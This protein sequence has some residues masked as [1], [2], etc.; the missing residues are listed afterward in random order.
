M[1]FKKLITEPTM[2]VTGIIPFQSS[3]HKKEHHEPEAEVVVEAI[4]NMGFLI[5]KSNVY[6]LFNNQQITYRGV[7]E[8]ATIKQRNSPLISTLVERGK[9]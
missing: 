7:T 5:G 2:L 3:Y 9:K 8:L 4:E 1:N 6:Y